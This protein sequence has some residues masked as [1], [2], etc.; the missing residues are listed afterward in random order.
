MSDETLVTSE[1][2]AEVAA[3]VEQNTEASTPDTAEVSTEQSAPIVAPEKYEFTAP[4]GQSF[5]PEVIGSFEQVARELNMPQEN[6]QKILDKMQP[7]L[8]M[9]QAKAMEAASSQWEQQA[10]ID[11]EFG[12]EKLQE[13]LGIAKGA[14]DKFGSAELKDL[15]VKSGL[16]NHP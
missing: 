3:P 8:A 9:Q 2:T 11:K 13:N 16:G 12:G 4:E 1:P 15:M 14:L 6:A 10:V 7:V 5:D